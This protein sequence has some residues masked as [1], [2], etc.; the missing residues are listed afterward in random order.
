MGNDNFSDN[1]SGDVT[2]SFFFFFFFFFFFLTVA[3]IPKLF[4]NCLLAQ[5]KSRPMRVKFC[6]RDCNENYAII[7][8]RLLR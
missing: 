7:W 6:M 2:L 8:E 4:S 1:F 5:P 3:N